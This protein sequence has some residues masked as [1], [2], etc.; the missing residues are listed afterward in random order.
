MTRI[1][2]LAAALL[3]AACAEPPPAW[4]P[5]EPSF[6]RDQALAQQGFCGALFSG[7]AA[8][9]EDPD[10]RAVLTRMG[11]ATAV[12]I[13]Q[14]GAGRNDP[15][16]IDGERHAALYAFGANADQII[17]A[18]QRCVEIVMMGERR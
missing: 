14:L 4:H 10:D 2:T 15:H 16:V 12:R 18:G 9:A 3:L 7:F 11:D 8:A 13:A 17:A 5:T 1:P 6:G